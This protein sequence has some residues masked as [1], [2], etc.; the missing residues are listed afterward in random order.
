[1]QFVVGASDD[2]VLST[3]VYGW[4][5]G[6]ALCV[7]SSINHTVVLTKCMSVLATS[8][9]ENEEKRSMW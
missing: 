8:F 9:V 3:L 4:R 6:V 1:M 5:D 2:R 7:S